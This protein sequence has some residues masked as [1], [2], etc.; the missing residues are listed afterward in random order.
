MPEQLPIMLGAL[1]G[2]TRSAVDA[3]ARRGFGADR[4]ELSG[5]ALA[6]L[7]GEI[8][9]G[10]RDACQ[11]DVIGLLVDAWSKTSEV[12]ATLADEATGEDKPFNII[13][14]RHTVGFDVDP[15]LTLVAPGGVRSRLPLVVAVD[16]MIEAAALV[17]VK[18]AIVAIET[19]QIRVSA[20]L[21]WGSH[22]SPLRLETRD[23]ILPGR[24]VIEPPI[25]IR[26]H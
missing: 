9:Q 7:H 3:G 26:A 5:E 21:K 8:D 2:E 16:V 18:H 1:F 20:V 13:L 10:L 25:P 14:G 4:L 6:L 22:E 11:V 19:G 17:V 24:R 23:M 15:A 12:R